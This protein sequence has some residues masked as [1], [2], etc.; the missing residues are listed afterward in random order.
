[1]EGECDR[2]LLT[3]LFE[4]SGVHQRV[5][6]PIDL[7]DVPAA[8]LLEHGL[9]LGSNRSRVIAMALEVWKEIERNVC[10]LM[11]VV[12]QDLGYF[13]V[14][15]R[16]PDGVLSTDY[17]AMDAYLLQ[18]ESLDRYARFVCRV[19]ANQ[20]DLFVGSLFQTAHLL[21]ALRLTLARLG[22]AV[23]IVGV[24]RT[25]T[26]AEGRMSIDQPEL[27]R[28]TLSAGNSLPRLQ[29]VNDAM[30]DALRDVEVNGVDRRLFARGHDLM[31]LLGEAAL[32]LGGDSAYRQESRVRRSLL[33][34]LNREGLA[35]E[36]LF[37]RVLAA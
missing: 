16:P 33:M 37:L 3:W 31:L 7:I 15:D 22:I 25:L 28:R 20:V 27:I 1:V 9:N 29:E 13:V 21:F 10:E 19:A 18:G 8:V 35:A 11:F 4:R 34:A 24:E 5:V 32:R 6:Y 12:D 36:N 26:F 2:E 14:E 17:S 30:A 23:K